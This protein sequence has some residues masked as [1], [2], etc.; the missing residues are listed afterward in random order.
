MSEN[1]RNLVTEHHAFYEVLPYYVLFDDKHESLSAS[2]RMIQAGFDVDVYGANIR[3]ELAPPGRDPDYAL[4]YAELQKMAERVSNF[5]SDACALE[6][7][8]FPS[9]VVFDARKH[10]MAEA[11]LRIRI[12]HFRGPDQP[13]GLP[14][15]R[16]L[17]EVE[18]ELRA[19]GLG[20]R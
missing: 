12:S 3:N 13:Y 17:A 16:A 14:E 15:Q 4:G 1:L 7:I 5:I 18:K 10:G 20:R 11:M 2:P 19:L 8:A 6:V 9:T